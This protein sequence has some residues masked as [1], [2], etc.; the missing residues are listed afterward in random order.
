MSLKTRLLEARRRLISLTVQIIKIETVVWGFVAERVLVL[1]RRTLERVRDTP[2]K[3]AVASILRDPEFRHPAYRL[4]A[5]DKVHERAD[6]VV[7]EMRKPEPEEEWIHDRFSERSAAEAF[8]L[9]IALASFA[10]LVLGCGGIVAYKLVRK[11]MGG[12][13]SG[14]TWNR[15]AQNWLSLN[16]TEQALVSI[17]IVS[18][19][20]LIFLMC[21]GLRLAIRQ[22]SREHREVFEDV[23][24]PHIRLLLNE[25]S[26]DEQPAR[27]RVD[28]APGLGDTEIAERLIERPEIDRIR[29]LNEELG[30]HSVAVSG[31][32]GVGKT[33][34]LKALSMQSP[35]LRVLVAAPVTYDAREF[36]IHLYISICQHVL[37]V[38]GKPSNAVIQLVMKTVRRTV[39]SLTL[40]LFVAVLAMG[41]LPDVHSFVGG[42][43]PLL[44][45]R[46]V[47]LLSAPILV[48]VWWL[49][50][51]LRLGFVSK[52]TSSMVT[53][54]REEIQLLKFL[55]TTTT[56]QSGGIKRAGFE[57]LRKRSRQV[58]TRPYTLPELVHSYRAFIEESVEWLRGERASGAR[59]L[60]CID[61]VDR[62]AK[63]EDAESFLNNIKAIFGIRYCN[64]VVTVSEDALAGFER[65]VVRVRPALDSAFDE[66]IRLDPFSFQQSNQLIQQSVI[67]MPREFVM[68]CHCIAGGI[69]RDLIRAVRSTLDQRRRFD[70]TDIRI[71][72]GAVVT[73]EIEALRRGLMARVIGSESDVERAVLPALTAHIDVDD[74]PIDLEVIVSTVNTDVD[75]KGAVNMVRE[76]SAALYF[77]CTVRDVFA[78]RS[79]ELSLRPWLVDELASIRGFLPISATMTI[80]H[81]ET[82]R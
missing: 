64:Y 63:A 17:G 19:L 51:R 3:A 73:S 20:L 25:L 47:L 79:I 7:A 43:V 34:L 74:S 12:P 35:T 16:W 27:L 55:Q 75:D 21:R 41:F 81:L 28:T 22:T 52:K 4:N 60:I 48:V 65:R 6:E 26:N 62:I 58:S 59:I 37:E 72:S 31:P 49:A 56:E 44:P 30:A 61:E 77:Y 38:A 46:V 76:F 13:I 68:L 2:S 80:A 9:F 39:R 66:V 40:L 11:W 33:T 5:V 10:A 32:R 78:E 71:I 53:R 18:L 8:W 70:F 29:I 69:P 45:N 54:C 1:L 15:L 57:A 24:R 67:G 23:L 82:F 14:Q 42:Y 50:G 36:L